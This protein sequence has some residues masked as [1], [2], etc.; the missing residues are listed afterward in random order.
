[1]TQWLIRRFVPQWEQVNDPAVRS[2]YGVVAGIVGILCNV[3]LFLSKITIGLLSGSVAILADAVNNLADASSSIM[4]LVGFRLAGRPADEEHP[5]GHA[6]FEYLAGLGVALLILIIGVE[7]LKTAVRKIMAPQPIVFSVALFAVL[8]LAILLKLW[9]MTFNRNMGRRIGSATLMATG[10]DS[11]N[12]VISTGG[13]LLSAV[14]VYLTGWN[15]DGY[16]GLLVALFILYS[17]IS[18]GKETLRPLIGSAAEPA[19][20]LRLKQTALDYH[21]MILGV[22]DLIVHDYGPG[23]CFATLHAEIDYREDVLHAHEVIDGLERHFKEDEHVDMVVHYDPIVTDD[24]DLNALR[25]AMLSCLNGLDERLGAHDFR[26]VRASEGFNLIFDVTIPYDLANRETD[27]ATQLQETAR[28]L[29]AGCH[30]IVCFDYQGMRPDKS[31]K[32][33]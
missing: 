20:L 12:D 16:V 10:A 11:R 22:H 14:L 25:P 32:K 30:T 2:R 26:L 4:T 6:R 28:T 15:L 17:G 23:R 29:Y 21:P 5:Y 1:M 18:I 7:T 8:A 27:I 31:R 19:L 9:M 3:L 13:V 33:E 24:E